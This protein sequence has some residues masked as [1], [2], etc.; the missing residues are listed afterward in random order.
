MLLIIIFLCIAIIFNSN[1]IA[2]LVVIVS[3]I[4]ANTLYG[5]VI[6]IALVISTPLCSRHNVAVLDEL[7]CCPSVGV[8]TPMGG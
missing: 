8:C 6:M 4:Y 7:S 1:V 3:D 5:Q 2:A